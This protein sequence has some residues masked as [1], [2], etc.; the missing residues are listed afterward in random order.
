MGDYNNGSANVGY[1][2]EGSASVGAG[3]KCSACKEPLK[4]MPADD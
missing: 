3:L 2:I 4:P 1:L